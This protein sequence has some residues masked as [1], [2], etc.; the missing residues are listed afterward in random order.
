[1]PVPIMAVPTDHLIERGRG[2][3]GETLYRLTFWTPSGMQCYVYDASGFEKFVSQCQA[4]QT[5]LVIPPSADVADLMRRN[6]QE[7]TGA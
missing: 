2:S 5:G 1:M 3:D 7:G 4:A 6:G